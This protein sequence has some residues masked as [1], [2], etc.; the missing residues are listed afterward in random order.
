MISMHSLPFV[1]SFLGSALVMSGLVFSSPSFADS[2]STFLSGELRKA[3]SSALAPEQNKAYQPGSLNVK[4]SRALYS[5]EQQKLT[6]DGCR[7][8]FPQATPIELSIVDAA[9]KPTPLC[10]DNF[11]VLYSLTS[12]TPLVVVQKLN[13]ALV[14]DA[15]G[16]QRTDQFF[17]DPRLRRAG[18]AELDDYRGNDPATDRGHMAPAADAPNP[19]AMAQSFS[20]SNMVPQ[21][22]QLN[23]KG[24]ADIEKATRHYAR[25]A[26]GDVFVFTGPL[27][28]PG[29]T[30]V[31][32]NK[33]WKP[34]RLFKLIYDASSGRAWA[35]LMPNAPA[36][37]Q[38]PI[39]YPTFVQQTGLRLLDHLP[40]KGSVAHRW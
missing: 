14:R 16:E 15:K 6:F 10:S 3:V 18:R 19:R 27:F 30:S 21:D 34:S 24:W 11:A 9:L 38:K 35:Y 26:P 17:P 12:K 2:V 28:D 23:R 5:A 22:P 20:L 39:D 31:G 1:R 13:A 32:P 29:F 36:S 33:V 4:E 25:R 7:D 37:V 40:L 8:Q